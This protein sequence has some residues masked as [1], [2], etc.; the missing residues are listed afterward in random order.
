MHLFAS[1]FLL[2]YAKDDGYFDD[3]ITFRALSALKIR[4]PSELAPHSLRFPTISRC[5]PHLG[6]P[7][8]GEVQGQVIFRPPSI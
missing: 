5:I 2:A 4:G 1:Y 8:C 6:L 7:E 3:L